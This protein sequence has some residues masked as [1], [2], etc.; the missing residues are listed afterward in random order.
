MREA[1]LYEP[2][3]DDAVLCRLC[4]WNCRIPPGEAGI[5]QVRQ[6]HEG[7]LQ[8]LNY[9]PIS[10]AAVEPI[11][12]RGVYHL[13]PGNIVLTLGGWGNNLRC[14]HRPPPAD[15]PA[16]GQRRFLD[17]ERVI[18]F[19]LERNCRGIGWGYQE[20]VVWLEYV[21]DCAMLAK[22]NGFFTFILTSGYMTPEALDLLGPY[23]N[24]YVVEILAVSA[25]PYETLCMLPDCEVILNT[26]LRAQQ[27]WN[28]H[29]EVHTPIIPQVNGSDESVRGMA[30]WIRDSLGPDTPWHLSRLEPTEHFP[31]QAPTSKEQL[32]QAQGVG[33]ESGLYYVYLQAGEESGLSSTVC[34]SCGQTLIRREGNFRIKVVGVEDGKCSRCEQEINLRRSIFK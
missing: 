16:E 2:L 26:T 33:R 10:A 17:P 4:P 12:R 28:C 1:T 32:E 18:S 27:E 14:R 34:P 24:A 8:T 21:L 19:A 7:M 31:E 5:C 30:S 15:L 23:L 29:V 13:F 11:E 20:P 3:D 6:N 22:A 25:E 9:G